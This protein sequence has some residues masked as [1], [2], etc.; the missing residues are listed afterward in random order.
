[1]AG[2]DLTVT[3]ENFG[4]VLDASLEEDSAEGSGDSELDDVDAAGDDEDESGEESDD[5]DTEDADEDSAEDDSEGDEEESDE[6]GD[7]GEEEPDG[8]EEESDEEESGEEESSD[9]G[10]D[11][12]LPEGVTVRKSKDGK[13]EWSYPEERGR[14]IHAGYAKARD[15]EE[16]LDRELTKETVEELKTA[17]DSMEWMRLDFASGTPSLQANVFKHFLRQSDAM[18][19]SGEIAADPVPAAAETFLDVIEANHPDAGARITNR[20]VQREIQRIYAKA[21]KDGNQNLFNAITHLDNDWNNKFEKWDEYKVPDNLPKE[22]RKPA[23]P[24]ADS[25]QDLQQANDKFVDTALES[26]GKAIREEVDGF[27]SDYK[28]R[29][30]K[31]YPERMKNVTLRLRQEIKDAIQRDANW[32]KQNE[33]FFSRASLTQ[34]ERIRDEITGQIVARYAAKAKK[35]LAENRKVISEDIQH[36]KDTAEAQKRRAQKG[37]SKRRFTRGKPSPAKL[38]KKAKSGFINRDDWAGMI[39]SL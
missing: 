33:Q 13:K 6:D 16:I 29:V 36:L 19:K 27:L 9:E 4:D 11:E 39:D 18:R 34:S 21:K 22:V 24:S 17:A 37:Q 8:D 1:M 15:A 14:T 25:G 38:P 20:I 5:S 7:E 23:Q 12:D 32:R 2:E 26:V 31:K 28:D 10:E 3:S 30:Y 35:V